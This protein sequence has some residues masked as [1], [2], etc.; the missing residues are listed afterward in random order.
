M[1]KNPMSDYDKFRK[2]RPPKRIT[3]SNIAYLLEYNEQ[4]LLNFC[5]DV[6]EEANFHNHAVT[7]RGLAG[8]TKAL[9]SQVKGSGITVDEAIATMK[10][11]REHL[12]ED[13]R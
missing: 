8:E 2:A 13:N 5:A 11:L 12:A 4:D 1:N 10:Q 9:A 6:C 3:P 7:L